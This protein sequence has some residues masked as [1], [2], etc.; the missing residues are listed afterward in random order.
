[1]HNILTN[2]ISFILPKLPKIRKEKRGIITSLI[3]GFIGLVHE[4]ISS[5]LHNRIHKALHRAVKAMETTINIQCNEL[6]HLEDP[7]VMYGVHKA[8]TLEK[9]INTVHQIHNTTTLNKNL[10]AGELSTAFTWYVNKKWRSPLCYKC[11]FTSKNIKR[12]ICKNIQK[13][14]SAVMHVCKSNKNSSKRLFANISYIPIKITRILTAVRNALDI[15]SPDYDIFIN[16]L[17]LYYDMKL[18]TFGIGRDRNVVIQFPVFIQPYPQQLL[19]LYQIETVLV[20]IVRNKQANSYTHLQIDKPYIALNS[21]MYISIRQQEL[22]TCKKIGY[23]CYYEE[24]FMVKHKTKYSCKST[25]YFNLA[26]ISLKKIVN[27]PITSIEQ[28]LLQQYLTQVMKLF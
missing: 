24:L 9:L 16:R 12:K 22:Q 27:L 23:K 3:S 19:I 5:F 18:V 1:M 4:G 2:K 8:E 25:I 26:Q 6:I 14:H 15:T 20:P 7:M 10:F 28:I 13:I 17:Y 11:T 21:K